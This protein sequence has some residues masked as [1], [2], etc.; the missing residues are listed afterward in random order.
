MGRAKGIGSAL[1]YNATLARLRHPTRLSTLDGPGGVSQIFGAHFAQEFS[2]WL[3]GDTT[4]LNLFGPAHNNG[5]TTEMLRQA[6]HDRDSESDVRQLSVMLHLKDY[7]AP[8][9][10]LL[11]PDAGEVI[12]YSILS[13]MDNCAGFGG[14]VVVGSARY[15]RRTMGD[16]Q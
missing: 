8:S 13:G 1:N 9:P 7:S 14:A 15:G 3:A 12:G 4:V 11:P 6:Q 16:G 10:S 2:R 5:G